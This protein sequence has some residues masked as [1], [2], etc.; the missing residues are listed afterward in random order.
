MNSHKLASTESS[1]YLN[2]CM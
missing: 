1:T 2:Y